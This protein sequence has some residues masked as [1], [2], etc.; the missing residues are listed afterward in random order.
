MLY[1]CVTPNGKYVV[2]GAAKHQDYKA[3]GDARIWLLSDGFLELPGLLPLFT[4]AARW[5]NERAHQRDIRP[6]QDSRFAVIRTR[7]HVLTIDC[8]TALAPARVRRETA[9]QRRTPSRPRQRD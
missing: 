4:A 3:P 9:V 6:Q 8:T 2:T 1:V 5:I 7:H